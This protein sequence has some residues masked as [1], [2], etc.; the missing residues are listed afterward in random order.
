M[1]CKTATLNNQT[2]LYKI[3]ELDIEQLFTSGPISRSINQDMVQITFNMI[4]IRNGRRS[5]SSLVYQ[6][7]AINNAHQTMFELNIRNEIFPAIYE[8]TPT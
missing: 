4:L 8:N 2:N 7:L 3:S 5:T 1:Y 6:M